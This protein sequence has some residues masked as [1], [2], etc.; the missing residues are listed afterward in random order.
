MTPMRFFLA[1]HVGRIH[2]H[3]TRQFRG[4]GGEVEVVIDRRVHPFDPRTWVRPA[5]GL[6]GGEQNL[7]KAFAG[8]DVPI[9]PLEARRVP[10]QPQHGEPDR[11][12]VV[13]GEQVAGE[14]DVAQR[15]GHLLAAVAHELAVMPGP[16]ERFGLHG[17][18][19][20]LFALVVREHQV[21]AAAVQVHGRAE[22][23]ACHGATADVPAGHAGAVPARDLR[24]AV[25]GRPPQHEVEAV[26]FQRV[27]RI[28]A[29]LARVVAA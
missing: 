7:Q 3:E 23:G 28:P 27:V 18:R 14:H 20:R 9:A 24:L 1:L 4:R 6:D 22:K 5:R 11:A 10:V 21:D 19:L 12:C 15:L 16:Y 17:H 25:A 13:A 8:G 26:A 2:H 29:T